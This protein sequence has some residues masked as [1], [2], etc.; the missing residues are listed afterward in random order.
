M[1]KPVP[2]RMNRGVNK[3]V[4]PPV[5]RMKSHLPE[6]LF[7]KSK[8]D[9]DCLTRSVFDLC[10]KSGPP[11]R[12]CKPAHSPAPDRFFPEGIAGQ[13][14]ECSLYVKNRIVNN[15]SYDPPIMLNI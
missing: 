11:F 8:T 3:A 7:F 6:D 1:G 2:G 4:E 9:H 14:A 5:H 10:G 15:V 12:I 13:I